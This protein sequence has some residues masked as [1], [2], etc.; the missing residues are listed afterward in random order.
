M[1]CELNGPFAVLERF[2]IFAVARVDGGAGEVE[3]QVFGLKANGGGV[4][5]DGCPV[6]AE[7]AV[8]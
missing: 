1:R 8:M 4:I 6:M 5:D 7:T 3:A 2:P